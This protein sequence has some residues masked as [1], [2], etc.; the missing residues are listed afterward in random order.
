MN[1]PAFTPDTAHWYDTDANPCHFVPCS[2]KEG[3]RPTTLRDAKKLRLRPSVTTVLAVMAKP[4]LE[5]W[6][7]KQGVLA[8]LT[9]PRE[10]DELDESFVRRVLDDSRQQGKQAAEEGTR[11]H[12][13]IEDHFKGRDVPPAY[14]PH[15]EGVIK[16]IEEL[17]PGVSDW[18]AEKTFADAIG[19][20]PYGGCVDLHSPNEGIVID[21]KGKDFAPG[22]TSRFHYDQ[23]VQLAAYEAGV[24]EHASPTLCNI[25]F[26]RT[27]PGAVRHHLWTSEDWAQGF[28]IFEAALNLWYAVNWPN[29]EETT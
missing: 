20:K 10:P 27:H 18:V 22:D 6:K 1:F 4:A 24:C 26:S 7:V 5:F 23:N 3:T 17:F 29:Y 13:A 16:T 14:Q 2:T 15:V 28:D 8:A 21:F 12:N 9:L 25:F 19:G 11:V